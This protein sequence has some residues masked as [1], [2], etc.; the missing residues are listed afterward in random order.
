MTKS[1]PNV[2]DKLKEIKWYDFLNP[3]LWIF[4]ICAGVWIILERA[5]KIIDIIFDGETK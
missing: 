3:I 4:L 1:S 2:K 5:M